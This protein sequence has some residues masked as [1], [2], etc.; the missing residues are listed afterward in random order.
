MEKEFDLTQTALSKLKAVAVAFIIVKL[1]GYLK[2]IAKM[3]TP[4][5]KSLLNMKLYFV[6]PFSRRK[7]LLLQ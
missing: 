6:I 4:P 3:H 5:E 7:R 2:D 1:G